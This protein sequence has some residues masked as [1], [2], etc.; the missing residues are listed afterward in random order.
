MSGVFRALAT[1]KIKFFVTLAVD[2]KL[3]G[4]NSFFR[5]YLKQ[6]LYFDKT[7]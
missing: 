1:Y 2:Q 3:A 4:K 6:E 7:N 5:T